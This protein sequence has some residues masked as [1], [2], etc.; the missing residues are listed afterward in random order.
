MER[1]AEVSF[2]N[3]SAWVPPKE[4]R[5]ETAALKTQGQGRERRE[6]EERG[7]GAVVA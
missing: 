6:S 5:R 3:A 4:K 2:Y 1:A 7:A